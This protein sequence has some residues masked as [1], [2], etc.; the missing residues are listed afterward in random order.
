MSVTV[1]YQFNCVNYSEY[2][3]LRG[4]SPHKK[5]L[6]LINQFIRK[7]KNIIQCISIYN[8]YVTNREGIV[9]FS[10]G[11]RGEGRGGRE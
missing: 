6:I 11:G 9:I 5:K 7:K 8:S 10:P 2:E 4:V 1:K 3:C